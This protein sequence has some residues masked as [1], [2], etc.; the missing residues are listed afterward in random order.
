[1]N[2][3]IKT[4]IKQ[5]NSLLLKL[6]LFLSIYFFNNFNVFATEINYKNNSENNIDEYFDDYYF[7][8][9]G[10]DSNATIVWDPWEPFNRKIYK[11]NEWVLKYIAK[12]LYYNVYAK[13]T[14][15]DMR[16]G[17]SNFVTNLKIPMTFANYVLQLDFRNAAAS[18]YS[19]VI[20]TTFGIGGIYDVAGYQKVYVSDTDLGITLGKYGVP[21]GPYLVLPFFGPNDLRGTLSWGVEFIVDPLD[22][23]IFDVGNNEIL[24]EWILYTHSF[25]Y[26]VDKASY[27]VV[28]FYDLMESS[29]DPYVMMR[30]AYG[31]S[32]NFKINN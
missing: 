7:D 20:N 13:I 27:A 8:D 19:F 31:Q 21:A 4:I 28:N 3:K 30:D 16:K 9:Y 24:N 23:N 1:M 11:F 14:T 18:L 15:A 25:L 29:F 2:K 6:L 22:Y 10:M 26:V 5:Q 17:V 32:Q 12:P